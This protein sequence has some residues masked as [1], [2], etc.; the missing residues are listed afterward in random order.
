MANIEHK[1]IPEAGLHE[2][3]GVSTATVGQTYIADGLGSG[4]WSTSS[5]EPENVKVINSVED[6]P[7]Q[8]LTSWTADAGIE[9]VFGS[10]IQTQ[11]EFIPA[12]GCA[13][14][15]NTTLNLVYSYTG[16]AAM[17][18][19]N[20]V[21]FEMRNFGFTASNGSVFDLTDVRPLVVSFCICFDCDRV[22]TI[23][24]STGTTSVNLYDGGFV[25]IKTQ[26]LQLSGD[27]GILAIREWVMATTATGV[28]LLDWSGSTIE[29]LEVTNMEA[30]APT[31]SFVLD[32][33]AGSVNMNTGRVGTISNSSLSSISLGNSLGSGISVNDGGYS[34][35]NSTV[36]DSKVIGHCY[37]STPVTT[38]ITAGVEVPVAGTFTQGNTASQT[39]SSVAGVITTN[40]IIGKH[41][42]ISV[43]LD[44][45]KVG[46]GADDYL[47]K[48]K[49]IPFSTGV[50][51][52]VD[53]G[54]TT[55][56]MSGGGTDTISLSAPTT[57]SQGDQ[58]Y[59][60]VEGQTNDDIEA[61]TQGFKVTE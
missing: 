39:T 25:N 17:I 16:T 6:L 22:G 8:T 38:N 11:L 1:D 54:F 27:V 15:G 44:I 26:G 32:C 41:G 49:K 59:I 56:T 40:N 12:Q 36:I 52:D 57:M 20:G 18:K 3:K 9:Y 46:G 29:D 13:L 7:N 51:E 55:I 24:T 30:S 33:D 50:A 23:T 48:A 58:F 37:V 5:F 47:F 10:F 21:G 53:G 34:F 2:P 35:Q 43:D 19:G 60:S 14:V 31:G 4:E 28:T 61:F 45:N 42:V